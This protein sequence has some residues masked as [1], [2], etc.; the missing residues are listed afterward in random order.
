[1]YSK[2]I[3]IPPPPHPLHTYRYSLG[4]GAFPHYLLVVRSVPS[5]LIHR[6]PWEWWYWEGVYR[7]NT[8]YYGTGSIYTGITVLPSQSIPSLNRVQIQGIPGITGYS[9][10]DI[11][12]RD[13]YL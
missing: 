4:F 8:V 6:V 11:L 7:S 9:I 5:S 3:R 2:K 1:M 10:E 12:L 13:Q